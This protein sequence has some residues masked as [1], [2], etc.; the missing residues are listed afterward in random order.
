MGSAMLSWE[1][2]GDVAVGTEVAEDIAGK[3]GTMVENDKRGEEVSNWI[4]AEARGGAGGALRLTANPFPPVSR[5]DC[6]PR[7]L[8]KARKGWH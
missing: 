6:P 4:E 8:E 5:H 3:T 7:E 2:N 1:S